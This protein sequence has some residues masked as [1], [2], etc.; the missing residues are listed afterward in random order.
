MFRDGRRW[1]FD[2][3][4]YL[5]AHSDASTMVTYQRDTLHRIHVIRAWALDKGQADAARA[6]NPDAQIQLEY[7]GLQ[8]KSVEG[9]AAG[10]AKPIKAYYFYDKD[11]R[12]AMVVKPEGKF[13][14]TYQD[15]LVA[16]VTQDDGPRLAFSYNA[17]GQLAGETGPDGTAVAYERIETAQGPKVVVR[18]ADDKQLIEAVQYDRDFRP[19]GRTLQDG[20]TVTWKDDG[21]T[22][23]TVIA[24]PGGEQVTV[25]DSPQARR[26]TI[27]TS[28]GAKH[29]V[30][31]DD[32]GRATTIR[33]DE[34]PTIKQSW[35]SDGRL[36]S[37][38]SETEAVLP[39]YT[40]TGTLAAVLVTPPQKA[41]AQNAAARKYEPFVRVGFDAEE[42]ISLL[43]DNTGGRVE[44]GYDATGNP[45][46]IKS[47]QGTVNV[48][49]GPNGQVRRVDTSWGAAQ[50]YEYDAK[51]EN[52]TRITFQQRGAGQVAR[53]TENAT[54]EFD[55]GRITRIRGFD[56]GET[57][58]SYYDAG[59]K[60][61]LLQRIV[62]A[63]DLPL[64]YDYDL[65][66]RL[67]TV[68]VGDAQGD[69]YQVNYEYDSANRLT[70][71][72]YS[73]IK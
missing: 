10:L 61:G 7:L 23:N 58:F 30:D 21:K 18:A 40:K 2:D 66:L 15:G 37:A 60:K 71:L 59:S 43:E 53:P 11:G 4:G 9:T 24:T 17:E 65:R 54:T 56:G 41:P 52:L 12:L 73:P 70:G 67:S 46:S 62:T 44:I 31:F 72:S 57:R 35:D 55:E 38:V 26:R 1:F 32:A 45:A 49:R 25:S 3:N 33:I 34:G 28:G 27:A 69:G 68:Q 64:N 14:Y 16:S 6:G 48:T 36:L 8:V 22:R 20:T 47:P 19:T 63:N 29:E 50:S 39:S 42:R 51:S 13:Q 5:V